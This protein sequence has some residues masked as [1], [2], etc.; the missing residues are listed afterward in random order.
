MRCALGGCELAA[1]QLAKCLEI[2]R[3]RLFDDFLRQTRRGRS[4][5]PIERLQIIA[6]KL[7]VETW[8]ALSYCVLVLRPEARGI[9]CQAFVDQKQISIDRAELKLRVCND[10]SAPVGVLAA[11]GINVK[12]QRSHTVSYFVTE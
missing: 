11:S 2:F 5:V 3:R 10:D 6:H 12:T 1:R 8:R 7:L 4:L 9:R